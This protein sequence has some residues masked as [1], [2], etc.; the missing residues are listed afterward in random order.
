MPY[1]PGYRRDYGSD[2]DDQAKTFDAG[3]PTTRG[4]GEKRVEQR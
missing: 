4:N 3:L 1:E 2:G